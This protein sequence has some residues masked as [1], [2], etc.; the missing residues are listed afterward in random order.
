MQLVRFFAAGARLVTAPPV[1]GSTSRRDLGPTRWSVFVFRDHPT[2]PALGVA[3]SEAGTHLGAS[4]QK[5]VGTCT[6]TYQSVSA[7][8]LPLSCSDLGEA[9]PEAGMHLGA[10]GQTPA[11]TCTTTCESVHAP[12]LLPVP[13]G[14]CPPFNLPE[15]PALTGDGDS[16]AD[17]ISDAHH[18]PSNPTCQGITLSATL[19]GRTCSAFVD[20]GGTGK[21][22]CF[23]NTALAHAL[24]LPVRNNG[25]TVQGF[26]SHSEQSAGTVRAKI[27][28]LSHGTR[29]S[30]FR[31]T[32]TFTL[33]DLSAH[34]L[35][36][37]YPFL[38][39]HNPSVDWEA[40]SLQFSFRGK[41]YHLRGVDPK[42]CSASPQLQEMSAKSFA[43]FAV[44]PSCSETFLF[45]VR[46]RDPS[47]MADRVGKEMSASDLPPNLDPRVSSLIQRFPQTFPA[48]HLKAQHQSKFMHRI[49]TL[50]GA[51]P[52]SRNPYRF[53]RPELQ[54]LRSQ[55]DAL[56][57]SERIRVSQSPYGAPVLFARKKDGGLRFCVDYRAL[58]KV[59]VKNRYPLP[60][61]DDL[62]DRLAK[63]RVFSSLD[64]ASGFWQIPLAEEDK[65]KTAFNTPLG[66]YEWNV[67]PFGLCN[68]PSTFQHMMDTVLRD[69]I[70]EGFVVC[71]LDDILIASATEQEHLAHLERVF[72]RLGQEGLY[73]KP[74]KCTFM[75]A[76]LKFLGFIIG[77]GMRSVDPAVKSAVADW[78]VPGTL[79]EL[80]SFVGF[81]NFYRTFIDNFSGLTA[82]LTSLMSDKVDFPAKLFGQHLSAFAATR[83]A[84]VSAPPMRL[85]D[86]DQPLLR[87]RLRT[88]ASGFAVGAVLEQ[89]FGSGFQPVA[90]HSKKLNDAQRN[91]STYDRELLAVVEAARTWRC[92]LLG[93][94]FTCVTDHAT[95]RHLMTQPEV[96]TGRRVRWLDQ[97]SEYDMDIV[98]EP[99][100]SNPADALSRLQLLH[101]T[102][103]GFSLVCE[104][105]VSPAVSSP[106]SAARLLSLHTSSLGLDP[107]LEAAI[108]AAYQLDPVCSGS[109]GQLLYVG[110][111]PFQRLY[112][113]DDP[114]VKR[115]IMRELHE[116]PSAAHPGVTRSIGLV[117]RHFF[118][119]G[120][121]RDIRRYVTGCVHCHVNKPS[122]R[123]PAGLL[124]PL[125]IPRARWAD[126]SMDFISG[127]PV[128]PDTR[129]D[130]ILVVVDRL[131]KMAH[132]IPCFKDIDARE[133]AALF[134]KEIFRLH[135]MPAS[136]V[137]D[138][139]KLFTSKFWRAL[140]EN[141]GTTLAL[142]TAWH[143]QTDG[144]TERTNRTLEEMLR[145]Y[146][147]SPDRQQLWEHYLPLAEFAYNNTPQT[148]TGFSPFFL[149]YGRNPLSPIDMLHGSTSEPPDYLQNLHSALLAA[150]NHLFLAQ[151]RMSSHYDKGR[152]PM[153][154]NVGDVV[155]I[156]RAAF[157]PKRRGTKLSPLF[158]TSPMKV[159]RRIGSSAYQLDTP[160][161][162]QLH[163][164]FHVSQLRRSPPRRELI[165]EEVLDTR[166]RYGQHLCCVRWR[167]SSWDEDSWVP[168][169][170]LLPQYA[171]LIR[172]YELEQAALADLY[173][174]I[175]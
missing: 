72:E 19:C 152:I 13:E 134:V 6:T 55:I 101:A 154:Y 52:Y 20:S 51:K 59:T 171:Q 125:P 90:Y 74:H 128:S 165:P 42:S 92:Y 108:L 25:P 146:C 79:T 12:A 80:R 66:Q 18:S 96:S 161:T 8:A 151:R 95:L 40:Q 84:L 32:L 54:E 67:M 119:P 103:H 135:G 43:R 145:P 138:R 48:E 29:E 99:G 143:P 73:C 9:S 117:S 140:F 168:R 126:I 65:H 155:Y 53:S 7:P 68:A 94:P 1:P 100:H 114:L 83:D 24:G 173:S 31:Q 27:S 141:L 105:W 47:S 130:C 49:A 113:P 139:D 164:V 160:A 129:H 21:L 112:V 82:P 58:N 111:A 2:P 81:A 60:R 175:T 102:P 56:L 38:Q 157:P 69:F 15:S 137:S 123:K 91:Y 14:E 158:H 106:P 37:G 46:A 115:R 142:S 34:D 132:F 86:P 159:V 75:Q 4:G 116:S 62:L 63:A 104:H 23:M 136:I 22:G 61:V 169:S 30:H 110:E 127:I 147:G 162:W 150:E 144:Q 71:Y 33:V 76:E 5:S 170:W 148:S 50:D 36:L 64:L 97:L 44:G 85:F 45:F 167:D 172:A 35:V 28:V 133:C 39:Q 131:S 98:Y 16:D 93:V 87:V 89:D 118:W 163:N 3:S 107:S 109:P 41:P 77:H 11:G 149:C 78:P 122:N 10:S 88:D 57:P 26:S 124:Q 17:S 121:T 174:D 120:M 70:T 166:R 153:Q 156:S